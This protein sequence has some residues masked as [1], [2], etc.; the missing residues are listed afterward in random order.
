MLGLN[1]W[2]LLLLIVVNTIIVGTTLPSLLLLLVNL[3]TLLL[4]IGAIDNFL[5]M[6]I[7]RDGGGGDFTIFLMGTSLKTNDHFQNLLF[8]LLITK[9]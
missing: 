3:L 6:Q 5:V 9:L 4:E 8:Q 2:R 7:A 1:L